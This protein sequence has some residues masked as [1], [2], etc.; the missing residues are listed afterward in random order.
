MLKLKEKMLQQNVIPFLYKN[1]DIW[2][3]SLLH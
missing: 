3:F 2:I 1:M